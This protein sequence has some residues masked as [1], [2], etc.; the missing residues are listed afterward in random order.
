MWFIKLVTMRDFNKPNKSL[1]IR[2]FSVKR[3][4]NAKG[5]LGKLQLRR[6]EEMNNKLIFNSLYLISAIS[7]IKNI[8]FQKSFPYIKN[9]YSCLSLKHENINFLLRKLLYK[10][11]DCR[12]D[13]MNYYLDDNMKFLPKQIIYLPNYVSLK[14]SE[15]D[16]SINCITKILK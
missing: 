3:V 1:Y 14:I 16:Y 10:D 15:L 5:F 4:S 13:W 9:V 6:L 12:I 2:N 8:S 11:I 7:R